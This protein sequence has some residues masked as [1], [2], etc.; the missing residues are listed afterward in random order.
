V[1]CSTPRTDLLPRRRET[2]AVPTVEPTT[3]EGVV[4]AVLALLAGRPGRVRL[5]VD[6]APA[7][8]A[9]ALAAT[10]AQQ[11]GRAVHVRAEGF[12]RPA[13]QR[14][15]HGRDDPDAWLDLWLDD[16]ALER[17]VLVRAVERG[18]VLPAL[19]DPVTDRSVRTAPVPVPDPG[20]VVVSGAGLL[21]RWLPFDVSV[22]LKV[23]AAA[24]RRRLPPDEAWVVEALGRYAEERS[25][26]ETAD[27]V[28]R[29][30]DPRHPA[31][32]RR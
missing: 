3:P 23:S 6:G 8:E 13:G 29:L 31:L 19:R 7:A 11:H 20:L 24:L 27:L 10:V 22:H 5:V 14:F 4:A 1:T 18:E 15:E 12:W 2:G 25:P 28:V 26:A 30:E 21:G 16:G 17:E 9:H 32:V